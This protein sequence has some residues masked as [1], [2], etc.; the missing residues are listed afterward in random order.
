MANVKKT[1]KELYTEVLGMLT[2]QE[3]KDF[4]QSRIN[5]IEKK[6]ASKKATEHQLRNTEL[7]NGIY[8]FMC[9]NE[10]MLYTITDLMKSVE[11]LQEIDP[12]SNQ[13]VTNLVTSLKNEGKV[14]RVVEKGRAKFQ[15]VIDD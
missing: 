11:C 5:A 2:S 1:H 8:E 6:S 9:D 12:L 4:I 10:G 14:E 15:A 3:H 13:F 7:A